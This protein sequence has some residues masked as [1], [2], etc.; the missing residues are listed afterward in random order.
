[1][2]LA[3]CV[4]CL[5]SVSAYSSIACLVR[6][7]RLPV[8][9]VFIG[10]PPFSTP[11]D[12]PATGPLVPI[13]RC[14][15]SHRLCRSRLHSAGA[16]FDR[17]MLTLLRPVLQEPIARCPAGRA[18]LVPHSCICSAC[19]SEHESQTSVSCAC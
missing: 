3:R 15:V 16:K 7:R 11:Q 13:A 5:R 19:P 12:H 9:V 4:R 6:S 2:L 10:L 14:R 18:R 1:M 8:S 17:P